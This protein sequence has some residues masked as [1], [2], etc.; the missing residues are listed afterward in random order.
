M[1][2]ARTKYMTLGDLERLELMIATTDRLGTPN[3]AGNIYSKKFLPVNADPRGR[4]DAV[5]GKPTALKPLVIE[6]PTIT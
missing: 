1:V 4:V 6:V 2:I 3:K 5:L